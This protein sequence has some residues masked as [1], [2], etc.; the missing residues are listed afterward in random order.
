MTKYVIGLLVASGFIIGFVIGAKVVG[1][2]NAEAI[3]SLVKIITVMN[4]G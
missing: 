1:I 3:A 2:E 4:G